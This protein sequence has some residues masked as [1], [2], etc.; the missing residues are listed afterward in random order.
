M[1]FKKE[2]YKPK[3]SYFQYASQKHK[4]VYIVSCF[5]YKKEMQNI[6]AHT[7]FFGKKRHRRRS[8][9]Q[10][11]LLLAGMSGNGRKGIEKKTTF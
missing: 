2:F 3:C 10:M 6:H 9:S 4:R 5:L 1:L 11:K 7:R 8:Q